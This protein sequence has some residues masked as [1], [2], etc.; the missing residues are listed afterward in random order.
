MGIRHRPWLEE[1]SMR[2]SRC[3]ASIG[4]QKLITHEATEFATPEVWE[5]AIP[6][7]LLGCE[8]HEHLHLGVYV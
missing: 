7:R 1:A 6:G 3:D 8:K 5:I 2:P 4:L